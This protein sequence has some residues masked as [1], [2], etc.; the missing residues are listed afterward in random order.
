MG[1]TTAIRRGMMEIHEQIKSLQRG[2]LTAREADRKLWQRNTELEKEAADLKRDRDI[3]SVELGSLW[4]DLD[5][6]RSELRSL[7]QLHG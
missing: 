7:R 5:G 2:F 6:L 4:R 1:R 3:Y